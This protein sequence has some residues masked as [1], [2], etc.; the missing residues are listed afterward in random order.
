MNIKEMYAAAAS[1]E[2]F[3][4]EELVKALEELPETYKSVLYM[5]GIYECT[6]DETACLLGILAE[7][8]KTRTQAAIKLLGE[9]LNISVASSA[10]QSA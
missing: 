1:S 4:Y 5:Q 10:E 2:N 3:N 7:E 8:V 9:K 6:V